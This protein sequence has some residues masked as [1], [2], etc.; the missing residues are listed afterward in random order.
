MRVTFRKFK[1]GDVIALFDESDYLCNRGCI[2]SYMHV[3]Q[4]SEASKSLA[5][6]LETCT[7]GE[8]APLK[9]E[10]ERIYETAVVSA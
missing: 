10:L 6:D 8:I 3:G 1:D 5:D 2:M 9:A 4:H 7:A